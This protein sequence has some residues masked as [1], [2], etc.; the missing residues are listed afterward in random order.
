MLNVV[1]VKEFPFRRSQDQDYNKKVQAEQPF[2]FGYG[3]L[4]KKKA[5]IYNEYDGCPGKEK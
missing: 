3:M 1:N 2:Y 5:L 4:L